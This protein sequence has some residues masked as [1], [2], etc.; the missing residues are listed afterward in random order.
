MVVQGMR[1][2]RYSIV[3]AKMFWWVAHRGGD[4]IVAKDRIP[5]IESNEP[6]KAAVTVASRS[7]GQDWRKGSSRYRR[8]RI[9]FRRRWVA[10]RPARQKTSWNKTTVPESRFVRKEADPINQT[11]I[12]L[13]PMSWQRR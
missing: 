10:E 12:E 13:Q 11:S 8:P 1:T 3:Q 4:V 6:M 5:M 9:K 7:L 2:I